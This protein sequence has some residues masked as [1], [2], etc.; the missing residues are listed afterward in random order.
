ML[1]ECLWVLAQASGRDA[2]PSGSTGELVHWFTVV[3][4]IVNFLILVFLLRHFLYGRIIEAMERR[5]EQ[6]ASRWDEA[7][8]RQQEAKDEADHYRQRLREL[9]ERGDEILDEAKKKAGRRR[10]ELI[11]EARDEVEQMRL[12]W[13]NALR[14]DQEA[15]LSELRRRAAEGTCSIARRAL[16]DLADADLE[17]QILN[18]FFRRLEMLDRGH[19]DGLRESLR[20]PN[21]RPI[22]RS[23]FEFSDHQQASISERLRNDLGSEFDLRFETDPSLIC[24]IELN[25]DG[26]K[27]AWDV[28]DYLNALL[29]ELSS[30]IRH[31]ISDSEAR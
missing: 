17:Q 1:I 25:A 19:R 29:E 18:T 3:A 5:Q 30:A 23:A 12:Q 2:A 22:L 27:L 20:N 8:Q 31:E 13:R 6:I 9:N 7:E 24:G 15:F 11:D 14:Q 26:R 21:H 28:F 4:Q 10:E 16:V